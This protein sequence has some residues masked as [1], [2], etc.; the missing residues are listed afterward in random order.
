MI[1]FL[2]P[3]FNTLL[4]PIIFG[5]DH[6][7][8]YIY[9]YIHTLLLACYIRYINDHFQNANSHCSLHTLSHIQ[10]GLR[11]AL[12]ARR[13]FP[14]RQFVTRDGLREVYSCISILNICLFEYVWFVFWFVFFVKLSWPKGPQTNSQLHNLG[15]PRSVNVNF[16]ARRR[17]PDLPYI[18][19]VI[20]THQ[21]LIYT[22]SLLETMYSGWVDTSIYPLVI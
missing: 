20:Y 10:Q 19:A 9:I 6:T 16:S 15:V 22:P 4:Y 1:S 5:N 7:L 17:H 3:L 8:I 14:R 12:L 21:S 2:F 11:V 13:R 18:C